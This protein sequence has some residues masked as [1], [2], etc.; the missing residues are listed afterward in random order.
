MMKKTPLV[1]VLLFGIALMAVLAGC[2]ARQQPNTDNNT[3]PPS[4]GNP[5]DSAEDEEEPSGEL[6]VQFDDLPARVCINQPT[7]ITLSWSANNGEIKGGEISWEISY[8]RGL[9][10]STSDFQKNKTISMTLVNPP[11]MEELTGMVK[12]DDAI[13]ENDLVLL[14][15]VT[16]EKSVQVELIYCEYTLSVIYN[17]SYSNEI[18]KIDEAGSVA[19]PLKVNPTTGQ[20]SGEGA[21]E[22]FTAQEILQQGVDCEVNWAGSIPVSISGLVE[23]GSITLQ[24]DYE[25]TV[26]EDSQ[27]TCTAQ[28]TTFTVPAK[29]GAVNLA[30][31]GLNNLVLPAE[32]GV[33]T[34][35]VSSPLGSPLGDGAGEVTI[36]L[37]PKNE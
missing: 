24:M 1:M 13:D 31:L 4:A 34:I 10:G 29:G 8:S 2:S 18:F 20:V 19:I 9:H 16:G 25:N 21:F 32:G 7:D 15:P 37:E 28:G 35:P 14:Y 26:I 33:K 5:N 23:N 12:I 22:F 27:I 3:P 36:N 17:G 6:N 11:Q 30:L